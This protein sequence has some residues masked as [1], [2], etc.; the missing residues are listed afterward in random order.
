MESKWGANIADSATSLSFQ[1]LLVPELTV[2]KICWS[3]SQLSLG[4]GGVKRK[5]ATHCEETVTKVSIATHQ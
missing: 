1:Y 5:E 3:F 2:A 4:E